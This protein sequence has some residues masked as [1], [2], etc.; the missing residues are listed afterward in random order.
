MTIWLSNNFDSIANLCSIL[1]FII[2]CY[3]M[4]N[5]KTIRKHFEFKARTPELVMQLEEFS[6]HLNTYTDD[7][8]SNKNDIVVVIK[9]LEYTLKSLKKKSNKE[10]ANHVELLL[11]RTS[12]LKRGGP[13]LFFFLKDHNWSFD[14]ETWEI[15]SDIQGILQGV[16]E[17]NKDLAWREQ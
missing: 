12:R 1:G 7:I 2:T 14:D 9:K 8:G 11:G 13:K 4:Y 6:R 15:Y 16:K 17:A 10:I 5:L 3:V